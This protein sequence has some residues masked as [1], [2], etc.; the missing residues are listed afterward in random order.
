MS[1]VCVG[2]DERGGVEGRV[3]EF[4]DDGG[5][6]ELINDQV[7]AH[8]DDDLGEMAA[9]RRVYDIGHDFSCFESGG[10]DPHFLDISDVFEAERGLGEFLGGLFQVGESRGLWGLRTTNNVLLVR[11]LRVIDKLIRGIDKLFKSLYLLDICVRVV[12]DGAGDGWGQLPRRCRRREAYHVH[13]EIGRRHVKRRW[14]D[15]SRV[16]C[17]LRTTTCYW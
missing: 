16:R 11:D 9:W 14:V 5:V 17:G 6:G 4:D 2:D 1:V 10:Q 12:L 13:V 3:L 7:A 15:G 8:V